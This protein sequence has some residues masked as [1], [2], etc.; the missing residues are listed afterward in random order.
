M[1]NECDTE[2]EKSMIRKLKT[3]DG[4]RSFKCSG[5]CPGEEA[6]LV[7]H[8][9]KHLSSLQVF[10]VRISLEANYPLA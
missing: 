3:D 8:I 9:V 7:A 10:W 4:L 2:Q 6:I 5:L 1:R